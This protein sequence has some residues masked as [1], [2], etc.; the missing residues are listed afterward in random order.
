VDDK[1][2]S[3]APLNPFEDTI[4]FHLRILHIV[5]AGF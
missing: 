4:G 5:D 3:G 1:S 2:H